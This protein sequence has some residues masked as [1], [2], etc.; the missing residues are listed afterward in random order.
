MVSILT[1]PEEPVLPPEPELPFV[2]PP[3]P[4]LK[5]NYYIITPLNPAGLDDSLN[6]DNYPFYIGHV[7]G[8]GDK[9]GANNNISYRV[10][11]LEP[12]TFDNGKSYNTMEQWVHA[13]YQTGVLDNQPA[14]TYDLVEVDEFC[15]M[16][17]MNGAALKRK[18]RTQLKI[19]EKGDHG[20]RAALHWGLQLGK[21]RNAQTLDGSNDYK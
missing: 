2:P 4:I 18:R 12:S 15:Q 6:Q 13:L 11:F 10:Q 1:P 3:F 21:G 19:Q 20:Q 9:D 5:D 8:D 16:I 7:K 14:K 17:Q